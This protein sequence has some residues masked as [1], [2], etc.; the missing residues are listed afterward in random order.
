[1]KKTILRYGIAALLALAS[2]SCAEEI[3]V[4]P[5][6]LEEGITLTLRSASPAT[7]TMPGV[8]ALNENKIN[9]LHY[10]FY[11]VD[12]DNPTADPTENPQPQYWGH[13]SNL[14][15]D[16]EYTLRINLTEYMLN[17]EVFPRPYNTCQVY[18]IANL[19][20][21]IEIGDDTDKS[22]AALRK[23]VL[24]G[25][26]ISSRT[27]D[28]FVMEGLGEA[29][30]LDRKNIIAATGT[31]NLDRVASKI[32][33]AVDVVESYTPVDQNMG[34]G[35]TWY[36]EP[37]SMT[38]ELVNGM[39]RAV[40]GGTPVVPAEEDYFRTTVGPDGAAIPARRFTENAEGNWEAAPFYS[41]PAAW[42]VGDENEPYIRIML[43]WKT[44]IN[45]EVD[46]QQRPVESFRNCYYKL[47]LGG[48]EMTRN[49]WYDQLVTIGVFGSFDEQEETVLD[50]TECT[51]YV[52]DWTTG[53]D[54]ESNI[55]GGRYLVVDRLQYEVYNEDSFM[56]PVTSSHPC[57]ITVTEHSKVDLYDGGDEDD[58]DY[59]ITLSDDGKYI[60]FENELNNDMNSND[61]DF[62]PYTFTFTVEHS[63]DDTYSQEI[64]I[65]QYP[66][67][68]AKAEANSNYVGPDSE[69]NNSNNGYVFVNGY[70]NRN[71]ND[72]VD[73]FL[74]ATGFYGNADP[75][76]YIFTVTST[77]GTDFII[78]DP[79]DRSVTY[80]ASDA[81]WAEARSIANGAIN[82]TTRELT[83]YYGTQVA[84]PRFS[85]ATDATLIYA[86]DVAAEAA[87]PTINMLAPKFRLA[88]GYAVLYSTD[89]EA[90]TL[91]NLKKRCASYQEDGYPAGRWRL[92]TRAEFQF[93]MT[94]INKENIPAVYIVGQ[95]YWCA[96]GVGTPQNDGSIE[97]TYVGYHRITNG[98]DN[99]SGHS[100]RC[101]YD[102]WYWTDKLEGNNKGVF[103][104]G[105]MVR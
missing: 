58:N 43:P 101:V 91:E 34:S 100:V 59:S 71:G 87:E 49:T 82:N 62:T 105:D 41:Y 61:F 25:D 104:W 88:S 72:D 19:P 23:I 68:Y 96:H 40:L 44:V 48:T 63:D 90:M 97:M 28:Y 2:V 22:L 11:P 38:I 54:M 14:N 103:T 37:E 77:T 16:G 81:D 75:N 36:S 29:Q 76:M 18:V 8:D 12:K 50:V 89:D 7:R 1:M 67:I 93:I 13:F 69:S 98:N 33:V 21:T 70:Q 31:I 15:A 94:Q 39:S 84:D 4:V 65:T 55:E 24:N 60:I 73:F 95:Q 20:E 80:D 78:G 27:Q 66:A 57:T 74:S 26:F 30:I 6:V 79:R 64:T 92:P 86:D 9:S 53:L 52:A 3:G 99:R 17:Y 56:I 42:N 35:L 102:E 47:I 32:S 51:Y 5:E 83:N 45:T 85:T 10:F 46:G